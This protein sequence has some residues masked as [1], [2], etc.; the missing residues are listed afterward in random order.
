MN[1]NV[2]FHYLEKNDQYLIWLGFL[3]TAAKGAVQD[4]KGK[5]KT[6]NDDD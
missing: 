6:F 1:C 3:F 2:V 5:K 4:F